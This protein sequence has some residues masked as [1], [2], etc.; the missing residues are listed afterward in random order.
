MRPGGPG[1]LCGRR[2]GPPW[3]VSSFPFPT[4]AVLGVFEDDS[5]LE[6]LLAD[7]VGQREILGLLGP[8]SLL[9]AYPPPRASRQPLRVAV[10]RSTSRCCRNAASNSSAAP[11]CQPES[12]PRPWR[13][14]CRARTRKW[15]PG[16]RG[17]Q[18]VVQASSKLFLGG[19][20]CERTGLSFTAFGEICCLHPQLEVTQPLDG[21]CRRL[22]GRRR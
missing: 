10:G 8:R 5:R 11:R 12:R 7:L 14:W 21:S 18:I 3:F 17:V 15:R 2:H 22:S 1:P 9:D 13:C 20:R 16:L 6:Q 19:L 4:D